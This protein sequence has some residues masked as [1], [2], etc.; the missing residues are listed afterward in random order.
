[1]Q[2]EKCTGGTRKQSKLHWQKLLNLVKLMIFDTDRLLL[3]CTVS[4]IFTSTVAMEIDESERDL[5]DVVEKEK[6]GLEK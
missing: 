4:R 2:R 1:M 5:E 6:T 3:R